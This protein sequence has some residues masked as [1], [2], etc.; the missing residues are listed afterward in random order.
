MIAPGE[1]RAAGEEGKGWCEL[2]CHSGFSLLD[3]ASTPGA[4]AARAAALGYP[5]LAL[6]DHDSLAGI[7][8]HATAC[9]EAGIRAIAGCE[10]TLEH[11][12]HLTLLARD[13]RGYRSLSSLLSAA[14]LAGSKGAPRATLADV[15]ARAADRKS[16]V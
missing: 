14:H 5:A 16:V 12:V 11:G 9:R 6:T 2:H 1:D 4:L 8:A 13:A 3:G 15:A 7:V 10:L